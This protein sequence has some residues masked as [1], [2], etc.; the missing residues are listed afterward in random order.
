MS[1]GELATEIIKIQQ[2]LKKKFE[3]FS[4]DCEWREKFTNSLANET[5]YFCTC[6]RQRITLCA[7]SN[8]PLL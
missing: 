3:H 8:C 7:L 2:E 1:N 5:A 6:P 4:E